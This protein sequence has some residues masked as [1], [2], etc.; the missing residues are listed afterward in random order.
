MKYWTRP[1][2]IL[3]VVAIRF[4]TATAC[5]WCY[6]SILQN[7]GDI[8]RITYLPFVAKV[9]PQSK[10]RPSLRLVLSFNSSKYG[11]HIKD[12]IPSIQRC[13][14][15]PIDQVAPVAQAGVIL[16]FFK[17]WA[18]YQTSIRC[19]STPIDQ[20]APGFNF[21]TICDTTLTVGRDLGI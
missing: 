16:Q 8:S 7:M 2:M 12:N 13:K 14:S 3:I 15:T 19:K 17:I 10:S 4:E 1:G 5:R 9:P 21:H 11:R 6:P 20:V 18:T